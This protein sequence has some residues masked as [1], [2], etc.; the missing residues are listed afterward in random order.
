MAEQKKPEMDELAIEALEEIG[1]GGV[2][3]KIKNM[4]NTKKAALG[5]GILAVLGIGA[6]EAATGGGWTKNLLGL[7]GEGNPNAV[8]EDTLSEDD[9]VII[10]HD[11]RPSDDSKE[12]SYTV[13]DKSGNVA[14]VIGRAAKGPGG[15]RIKPHKG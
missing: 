14:K 11:K 8:S 4:S 7:N 15:R 1:G 2:I 10:P 12:T 13:S 9:F 5:T 6:H 3:D